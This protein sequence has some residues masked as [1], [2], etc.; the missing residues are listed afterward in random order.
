MALTTIVRPY[1]IA[2]PYGKAAINSTVALCKGDKV[3]YGDQFNLTVE[4][5]NTLLNLDKVPESGVSYPITLGG[6]TKNHTKPGMIIGD[7]TINY[8]YSYGET[9][10]IS[11][12]I[13]TLNYPL[14]V[15]GS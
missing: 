7:D 4:H 6:L 3:Y 2:S 10:T 1:R 9:V 12:D 8:L 15:E 5:A 14:A 11:D 13:I